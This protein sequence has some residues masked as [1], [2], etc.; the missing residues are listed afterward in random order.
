M[1]RRRSPVKAAV[2]HKVMKKNDYE[3]ENQLAREEQARNLVLQGT[4]VNEET[5]R[6]AVDSAKRQVAEA[7]EA[8]EAQVAGE[9]ETTIRQSATAA[10]PVR[11]T[12][13][14]RL[15]RTIDERR[16][17]V[18]AM[19]PQESAEELESRRRRAEKVGALTDA[20]AAIGN[21]I[22]AGRGSGQVYDPRQGM[23]ERVRKRYDAARARREN[24]EQAWLRAHEA[25]ERS[26]SSAEGL[27]LRELD[28]EDRR[29]AR[30]AETARRERESKKR[31]EDIDNRIKWRD[32][33]G[34]ANNELKK[35]QAD[36]TKSDAANNRKMTSSRIARNS[37]L[38]DATDA[39]RKRQDE[40]AAKKKEVLE[41]Q[42]KKYNAEAGSG[43]GSSVRAERYA[44]AGKG[45]V[46]AGKRAAGGGKAKNGGAKRQTKTRL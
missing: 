10:A 29:K 18:E 16:K 21:V 1:R 40:L 24:Q 27:R 7:G 35:A 4:P 45:L 33:L 17:A 44:N 31:Q 2:K 30:E 20:L 25:L 14:G 28:F 34:E 42:K 15:L 37:H 46:A 19:K 6:L 13:Y 3:K 36:K 26:A 11:D 41:A 23:S 22:W 5:K 39:G 12:A 9:P 8:G 38:N 43:G 32:T